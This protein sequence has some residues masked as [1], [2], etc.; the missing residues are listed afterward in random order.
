MPCSVRSATSRVVST[1]SRAGR[2]GRQG[3][4]GESRFYLSMEDDLMRLF[5]PGMAQRIMASGSSPGRT[6]LENRIVSR[7][8]QSAQH[9]V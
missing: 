6:C 8:I 3:D 9:Q 2:S 7:S 5:N 4:Q 1:T